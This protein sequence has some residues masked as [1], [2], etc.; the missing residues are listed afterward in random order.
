MNAPDRASLL[1]LTQ[2]TSIASQADQRLICCNCFT[3]T[4]LRELVKASGTPGECAACGK[5]RDAVSIAQIA[6]HLDRIIRELYYGSFPAYEE[7]YL[8]ASLRSIV[9]A[10]LNEE[11]A[12]EDAIIEALKCNE[13]NGGSEG[14]FYT[15]TAVYESRQLGDREFREFPNHV[16]PSTLV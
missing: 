14:S 10:V 7:L 16:L 2:A 15:D 12:Y 9:R 5:T 6:V 11:H 4:S 1:V 13:R 3:D 8:G